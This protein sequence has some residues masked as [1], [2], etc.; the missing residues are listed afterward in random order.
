MP[1]EVKRALEVTPW[2]GGGPAAGGELV[3]RGKHRGPD[4]LGGNEA[5]ELSIEGFKKVG[6]QSI[7][8]AKGHCFWGIPK[9]R[10]Q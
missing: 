6:G 10:L 9:G 7:L 2:G 1:V 4:T 3:W 5:G 8:L